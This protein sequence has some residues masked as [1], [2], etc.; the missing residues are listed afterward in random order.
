MVRIFFHV[1]KPLRTFSFFFLFEEG[2]QHEI[3]HYAR[4]HDCH[5]ARP[6]LGHATKDEQVQKAYLHHVVDSSSDQKAACV[7]QARAR[8][9]CVETGKQIVAHHF[10]TKADSE[11]DGHVGVQIRTIS[12]EQRQEDVVDAVLHRRA[13]GTDD[14]ET[15]HRTIFRRQVPRPSP[16]TLF[17]HLAIYHLT[18]IHTKQSFG[19]GILSA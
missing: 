7:L 6:F 16:H 2:H 11:R 9:E 3:V 13:D 5:Y 18:I 1:C 8:T 19:E 17:D 10:H 14:G 12:L 4:Q 15:H